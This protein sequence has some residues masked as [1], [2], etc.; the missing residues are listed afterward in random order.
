[1]LLLEIMTIKGYDIDLYDPINKLGNSFKLNEYKVVIMAIPAQYIEES[2][3]G[4]SSQALLIDVASVKEYPKSI[5]IKYKRKA[6]LT[7]PMFGPNSYKEKGLKNQKIMVDY[8]LV[9]HKISQ[10]FKKY[11]KNLGLLEF[12]MNSESHDKIT[13][14]TL[15]LHHIIGRIIPELFE[16]ELDTLNYNKI[17]SIYYSVKND[18]DD[19]FNSLL[20]YNKY[21]KDIIKTLNSNLEKL[22]K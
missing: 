6:I 3:F 9:N 7:H 1:M 5:Y 21:S 8:S 13:A 4:L 19:L 12:E 20:K 15:V 22:N 17:K 2:I 14:K 11:I 16:E 18:S 10:E